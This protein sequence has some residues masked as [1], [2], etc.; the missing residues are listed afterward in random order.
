MADLLK[1]LNITGNLLAGLEDTNN[2]TLATATA[3]S[4][5]LGEG[6]NGTATTLD[7]TSA[8]SGEK[9]DLG[10]FDLPGNYSILINKLE[11]LALGLDSALGNFTIDR[12]EVEINLSGAASANDVADVADDLFDVLPAARAPPPHIAHGS[13]IYTGDDGQD[14]AHVVSDIWIGVILTLLIVFVIFF[15]CACFVYHKFQQWKNSYRANHSDPT[16]EICRRCPPD[17]EAE[18]L[19]SYTI[20]SGLPTYDDALEE[21]RKAGIILTPAVVPIIK[22]F[23]CNESNGKEQAV[24]Y[25]LVET[26]IASADAGADNVSLASTTCNC[27]NA[28]PT[29]SLPSYS[30]ATAA[31]M[32]VAAA[33][34]PQVIELSP[35]HLASLSQKRLSL[36][37]S[38]NNS[39]RR[40]SPL[41]NHLLRSRAVGNTAGIG[42]LDTASPVVQ[43][44]G[45]HGGH[46]GGVTILPA[47]LH[48]STSTISLSN[49]RQ[50]LDQRLRHL[51]HRGSLY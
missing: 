39:V 6:L 31:A 23:E 50:L 11:Q 9:L 47:P 48:R 46:G 37:I 28:S 25:S 4:T 33:A 15:I 8:N 49:E 29:S 13:R 36:Q 10:G 27:G 18:S 38:F 34:P 19:P 20:V 14:F 32:A 22:I 21:F 30:A 43:V 45:G 26:N 5:T 2:L 44:S 40:Q 3:T 42:P 17:Y 41:R 1:A 51:H 16:I 7:A 35:E 12:Q 24:G